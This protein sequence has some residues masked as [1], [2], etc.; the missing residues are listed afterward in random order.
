VNLEQ[1]ETILTI[2]QRD[3]LQKLARRVGVASL[4]VRALGIDET[5]KGAE[6]VEEMLLDI[7]AKLLEI[8]A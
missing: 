1:Q 5:D 3:I 8:A 4:A 7:S 6:A 2:D